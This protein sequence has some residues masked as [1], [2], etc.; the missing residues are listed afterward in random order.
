MAILLRER[1]L[2]P[3]HPDT[4]ITRRA[5]AQSTGQAGD[6]AGAREPLTAL[7][8]TIERVLGADHPS[9]AGVRLDLSQW[10]QE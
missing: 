10:E 1:V 5:L 6:M 2:G 8:P 4:R 9:T 7:L 3:E